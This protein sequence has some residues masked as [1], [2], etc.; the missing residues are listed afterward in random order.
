MKEVTLVP[1]HFGW[2]RGQ[3]G[4]RLQSRKGHGLLEYHAVRLP[5]AGG[6]ACVEGK[7]DALWD[8]VLFSVPVLTNW[9]LPGPWSCASAHSGVS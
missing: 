9:P 2:Q 5:A 4:Q 8:E 6:A 3:N 7:H 1:G